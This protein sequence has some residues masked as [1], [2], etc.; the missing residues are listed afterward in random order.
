M[1][2][3]LAAEL[4]A[5]EAPERV[6]HTELTQRI[7]SAGD[8]TILSIPVPFADRS[9]L[10]LSKV[11]QELIVRAGREKRTIILPERAGQTPHDRRQA[12]SRNARGEL[13]R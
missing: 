3:R 8:R 13:R 5:D 7:S 4:F 11:G 6:M 9:E 12:R 2:D 1:L 10:N